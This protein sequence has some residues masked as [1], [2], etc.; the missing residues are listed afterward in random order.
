M[1][2]VQVS[3]MEKK[4]TEKNA[5]KVF[6]IPRIFFAQNGTIISKREVF[7]MSGTVY[8][9]LEKNVQIHSRIVSFKD[10][11]QIVADDSALENKIRVLKLPPDTVQGPGRYPVSVMTLIEL[12]QQEFPGI[13]VN[14]I[15][16]ADFILTLEKKKQP[17]GLYAWC[18]TALVALIAFFGAA[19]AIMTFNNDVDIPKL[20]GQ[21]YEQFTGRPS[22]GFTILE[23]T[24]SIGIG[25]GVLIFFNHFMGKKLTA[26]P[27]PMEVEMRAY[28]DQVDTTVL[29][30]SRRAPKGEKK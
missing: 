6:L 17:G 14:N 12:I 11:A 19:F 27:T 9:K 21:L 18:K 25:L 24:Y 13:E 4:D 3:R 20:F 29:E 30:A 23:V 1:T 22:N 7:C 10:I 2:Q 5:G 15:G 8:L 26:D 28:E 16:E